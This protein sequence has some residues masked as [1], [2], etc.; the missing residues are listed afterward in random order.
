[1][2]KHFNEIPI[3]DWLNKTDRADFAQFCYI[4]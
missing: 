4:L 3:I 2:N 1:M